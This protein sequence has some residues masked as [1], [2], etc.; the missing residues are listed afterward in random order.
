MEQTTGNMETPQVS[1]IV[2]T[3][4]ANPEKLRQTL[5]SIAAQ[6]EVSYELIISD[7]GSQKKDFSFLPAYLEAHGVRNWWLLEHEEN[8]GTVQSCFCAVK[9]AQGKYIFLTSPGD[10]LYDKWVLRD[11]YGFAQ[12]NDA[13]L[14]FGNAVFYGKGEGTPRCTRTVGKPCRPHL[15]TPEKTKRYGK[16][17]FFGGDWIIGAVYF[18]SR[19][20]FLECLE[21]VSDTAKYMEDT[22]T[23][24]FALAMGHRVFYCDRN[25]AWY[26]DGI[27]VS[28]GGNEKWD[29]LLR[30]DLLQSFGKLKKEYPRDP[31]VD[32]AWRNISQTD[33]RKRIAGNLL[34]HG[35]SMLRLACIAKTKK[36]AIRCSPE[37]ILR[38]ER[39]LQEE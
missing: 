27:G 29:R 11:L 36:Q 7:D 10:L 38:L 32:I 5:S 1:V 25:V 4:N 2:L 22:T 33:R 24:A 19:V 16:L 20:M 17:N 23:T 26:E 15:Y 39:Q 3:Y 9:A 37:D 35:A 18:R 28:T 6:E 12:R 34:H 31:C 14:C 21:K 30:Q 13:S 8:R